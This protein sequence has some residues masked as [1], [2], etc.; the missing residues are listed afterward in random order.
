MNR[1]N[2]ITHCHRPRP[3]LF[4]TSSTMSKPVLFTY[5]RSVWASVPEL[6]M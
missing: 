5:S 3:D 4:S 2:D 6:A 1:F